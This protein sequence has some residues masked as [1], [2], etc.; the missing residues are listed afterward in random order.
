MLIGIHRSAVS[1]DLP[2]RCAQEGMASAVA[3]SRRQRAEQLPIAAAQV[4]SR[5]LATLSNCKL[6]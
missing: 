3:G 4:R 1:Q 6:V 2:R 5:G